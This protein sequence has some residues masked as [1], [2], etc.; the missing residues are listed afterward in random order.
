MEKQLQ[1]EFKAKSRLT[2]QALLEKRGLIEDKKNK[3]LELEVEGLGVLAFRLPDDEDIR[4]AQDCEDEDVMLIYSCAIEPS[5]KDAELQA[6]FGCTIPIEIVDKI[7][8]PGE[9]QRVAAKLM[10]A[11]GFRRDAV[12]VVENI[13]N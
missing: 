13:K 9:K 2:A 8:L 7:F 4:E 10:E 6:G 5:L 11:A 1:T 3:I 12:K